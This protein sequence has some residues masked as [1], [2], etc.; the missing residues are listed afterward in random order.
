MDP[1]VCCS[2]GHCA[3]LEGLCPAEDVVWAGDVLSTG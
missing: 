3:P 2:D 1:P